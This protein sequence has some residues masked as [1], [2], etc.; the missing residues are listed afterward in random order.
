MRPTP[1]GDTASVSRSRKSSCSDMVTPVAGGGGPTSFF[2]AR[3]EDVPGVGSAGAGAGAGAGASAS[4]ASRR[5]SASDSSSR[6]KVDHTYTDKAEE[7]KKKKRSGKSIEDSSYDS[8]GVQSLADALG[9][10][11]PDDKSDGDENEESSTTGALKRKRGKGAG[12]GAPVAATT[13]STNISPHLP[14]LS[15]PPW[16]HTTPTSQPF[17]PLQIESPFPGSTLGSTPKS[18]SFRSLRLSDE[19][20]SSADGGS[21]AVHSSG[22]EKDDIHQ[23]GNHGLDFSDAPELVMPSLSMP[24]RRPFTEKGRR[25]GRVKMLFAGSRGS[26]KTSLIREIVKQCP[27]IVHMD[28][29]VSHAPSLKTPKASDGRKGK[30]IEDVGTQHITEI[31]ASTRAYPPWWSEGEVGKGL[32]RRRKSMGDVI[33]ERNVCFVDTPGGD[34]DGTTNY[35][36]GRLRRCADM[37]GLSDGEILGVMSGDG[38]GQVDVC[39]FIFGCDWTSQDVEYCKKVSQLTNVIPVIG[40]ADTLDL[41]AYIKCKSDL[42]RD[43]EA[44]EI[45]SFLFGRHSIFAPRES[46]SSEATVLADQFQSTESNLST[47]QTTHCP[48]FAISTLPGTEEVEMDASLLMSSTYNAPLDHS[49]LEDLTILLFDLEN[50]AWLRHIAA[51][52]FILWRQRNTSGHSPLGSGLGIRN[53]ITRAGFSQQQQLH[54]T[55]TNSFPSIR[56]TPTAS[57]V[58]VSR[59]GQ[60]NSSSLAS[61]FDLSSTS[62]SIGSGLNGY[63]SARVRD[64]IT[65]EERLAHVQL[66]KWAAELQRTLTAERRAYEEIAGKER[67]SWLLERLGE[68]VGNG[69]IAAVDRD[70]EMQIASWALDRRTKTTRREL[71]LPSWAVNGGLGGEGPGGRMTW[72]DPLRLCGFGEGVKMVM[73]MCVK[74]I[75]AGVIVGAVLVGVEKV[76]GFDGSWFEKV[77]W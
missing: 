65:S 1:G 10:A 37:G 61:R 62:I 20:E 31:Y 53:H 42:M 57:G 69:Q 9:S 17:T 52:K 38:G 32:L 14:Q 3:E 2:M 64:H 6:K 73:G 60:Q 56:S 15:T 48:P 24:Q 30:G 46:V 12:A 4:H 28:P 68:E 21:Q 16:A 18:G 40:K 39:L 7:K 50:I 19:E 59:H 5:G 41:E 33:L 27:D 11:F 58:L 74:V 45:Q 70:G 47:L 77:R 36:E 66:V 49:D 35:V 76:W 55:H 75:G 26:G 71:R 72:K 25:M 67:A 8:Y 63:T 29:V 51:R 44:A 54:R 34:V 43:L 22:D 13:T 23:K